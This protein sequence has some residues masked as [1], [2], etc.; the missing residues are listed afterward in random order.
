MNS[1]AAWFVRA[2]KPTSSGS[3]R[4]HWLKSTAAGIVLQGAALGLAFGSG[5]LAARLLDPAGLGIYAFAVALA[6]FASVPAAL[7]LPGAITRFLAIYRARGD[8][9]LARGLLHR[10]NAIVAV[11]SCLAAAAVVVS[12]FVGQHGPQLHVT[13]VAAILVPVLAL[14]GVRQH[15]LQGLD[16]PV[17]AQL[18]EQLVKHS[19]FLIAAGVLGLAGVVFIRRPLGLMMI[20]VAGTALSFLAGALLLWRT[21]PVPLRRAPLRYD[22]SVW[23]RVAVPLLF[24]DAVGVVYMTVDIILLGVMRP[25]NEVGFYQVA[26]RAAAL[27]LV[28]VSASSYALAPWFAR[29]HAGGDRA[30]L[31]GIVR[32]VTRV[33]F[34]ASLLVFAVFVLW[35]RDLIIGIFGPAYAPAYGV[36]LVLA[37]ARL[38]DVAAGPVVTLL[39]MTGGQMA[40]ARTV[41]ATAAVNVAGCLLLIPRMGMMGA[42][43]S[44]AAAMVATNLVLVWAVRRHLG[45]QPT[46]LGWTR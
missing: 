10:A 23:F 26:V 39:S 20:W 1:L 41:A 5:V 22:A 28:F 29:L 36:L 46:V 35:G 24:A 6:G 44:S 40:V 19:A 2:N 27:L 37:G 42:A 8:W 34:V 38:V 31:A 17:L 14:T 3:L 18:P 21:S 16:H 43:V 30:R 45:F 13:L 32:R 9:A 11:A 7:G 25:A 15:A 4:A 33:V 12:A